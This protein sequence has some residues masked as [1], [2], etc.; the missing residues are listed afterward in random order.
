VAYRAF[1]GALTLLLIRVKIGAR[2]LKRLAR[3][4]LRILLIF[5]RVQLK[6]IRIHEAHKGALRK[7][8]KNFVFLGVLRGFQL[9]S[10]RLSGIFKWPL[11]R[12]TYYSIKNKR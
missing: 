1:A 10:G 3:C 7:K 8:R 11:R 6:I 4:V 2:N 9:W 12:K 5:L